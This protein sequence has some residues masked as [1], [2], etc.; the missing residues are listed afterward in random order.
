MLLDTVVGRRQPASKQRPG[1]ESDS[2]VEKA[3]DAGTC[4][5]EPEGPPNKADDAVE[6]SSGI[7]LEQCIRIRLRSERCRKLQ[8]RY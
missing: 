1:S 6:T 5:Q 2:E 4:T 7:L 3:N 8:L